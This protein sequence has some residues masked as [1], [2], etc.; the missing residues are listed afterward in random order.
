M[1]LFICLWAV[2]FLSGCATAIHRV[3]DTNITKIQLRDN[4]TRPSVVL[5]HGCGGVQLQ[6]VVAGDS[7]VVI[8]LGLYWT[9]Q[10]IGWV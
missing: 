8:V 5:V 2:F 4:Q 3:G 7:L 9:L 6:V 1:H 10:R